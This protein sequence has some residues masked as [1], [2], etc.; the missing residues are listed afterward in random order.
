M[1][2][3]QRIR[4]A[5]MMPEAIERWIVS[6]ETRSNAAASVMVHRSESIFSFVGLLPDGV[7]RGFSGRAV[8]ERGLGGWSTGKLPYRKCSGLS[9]AVSAQVDKTRYRMGTRRHRIC[10]TQHHRLGRN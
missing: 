7:L 3:V 9:F 2:T 6:T 1:R 5:G 4:L 8:W 10:K